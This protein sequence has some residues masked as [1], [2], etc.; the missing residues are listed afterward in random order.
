[1]NF[2]LMTGETTSTLAGILSM[3]TDVVSWFITTM[4]SYLGFIT[5][6]PII[7]VMFLLLLA[8]AGIGFLFRIWHSA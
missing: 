6:N 1:M 7:L 3:G 8:G 5:G 4:T 2:L